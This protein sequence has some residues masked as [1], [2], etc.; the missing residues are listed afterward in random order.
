M[1]QTRHQAREAA[2]QLLY[3]LDFSTWKEEDLVSSEFVRHLGAH[4]E[5]FHIHPDLRAFATQLIIGTLRHQT[6][7]DQTLSQYLKRWTLD[8]IAP[9]DRALLRLSLYELLYVPDTPAA[10]VLNEAIELAKLFGSEETPAFVNG[11]LD[12][13]HKSTVAQ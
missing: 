11:V 2:L 13:I 9:V 7:I 4:F 12:T 6:K 1:L 10:V 5:H 3:Q 8:R